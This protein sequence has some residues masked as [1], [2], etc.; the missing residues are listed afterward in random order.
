MPRSTFIL[1]LLLVMSLGSCDGPASHE[2]DFVDVPQPA[3]AKIPEPPRPVESGASSE[4]DADGCG[5]ATGRNAKGECEQLHTRE[6]AYVQQVQLPAGRFVMG[7]IPQ[8]YAAEI[9]RHDPRE[10]WAGQP[11]RYAEAP[12]FWIDLHE[13]TR[14]AYAKCVAAGQ[15]T[16]A[17]CPDGRDPVDKY[18]EDAARLVPQTCVTHEQAARFCEAHEGRLPT[19][20]EWEY[21]ARGPDARLFPWGN[22]MRDEYTAMLMP[23]SATP[24][25]ISYFGIRG[26][27]TSALEWIAEPYQVD[28]GLQSFL[29]GPF[30]RA[31]GPLLRAESTRAPRFVMKGG[32]AGARRDMGPAD[33]RVGFRC[34]A[35]LGPGEEPLTVPAEPPAIPL[36]RAAGSS[37]AVFGGVVEAVDRREAE[38]FCDVLRVE[39]EGQVHEDWRLPTLVEVQSIA[40]VFRGPGPFWAADGAIVQRG[41]GKLGPD[42]PWEQDEAEPSDAL[43]ARCVHDAG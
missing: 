39:F 26:M 7:D 40:Q 13:V 6:L 36:M 8:S 15:C 29:P 1:P 17:S 32:K 14:E 43:V 24:G 35:D 10:R 42:E 18:S 31:D 12:A 2:Y 9:G 22:D 4:A 21:A 41:G 37:L 11:P 23:I 20:I 16:E 33:P 38:A 34:V 5:R 25:D 3:P 19:E 28:A 27:G 30:R